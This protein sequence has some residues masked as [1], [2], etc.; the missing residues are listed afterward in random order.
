MNVR[1]MRR[2]DRF[3]GAPL[4]FVLT[5]L[6][7]VEDRLRRADPA[8]APVRIAVIKLAEQGATVLA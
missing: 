7:R 1:S 3:V 2:V 8:A 5:L 4:C 6:R